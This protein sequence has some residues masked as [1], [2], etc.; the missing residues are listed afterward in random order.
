MYMGVGEDGSFVSVLPVMSLPHDSD[1]IAYINLGVLVSGY[2]VVDHGFL[3][4]YENK[5]I[6]TVGNV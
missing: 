6:R 3:Y 4:I 2:S 1:E 5:C